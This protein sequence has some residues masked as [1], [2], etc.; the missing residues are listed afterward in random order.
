VTISATSTDTAGN[1]SAATTTDVTKDTVAPSQPTSASL[2][3]GG[4][5]GNAFINAQNLSTGSKGSVSVG[6]VVPAGAANSTSDTVSVTITDGTHTTTPATIASPGSAGGTV[7]PTG[8]NVGSLN[9]GSVTISAVSTDTAGNPSTARTAVVTKDTVAPTFTT[10]PSY[11]D[12]NNTAQD[13]IAGKTSENATVTAVETTPASNTFT[14]PAT[15][16]ATFTVNVAALSGTTGSPI[17][18][19]YSVTATD[20]AGNTSSPA[21]VVSGNDTK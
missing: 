7:T 5:T 1:A 4:G 21:V 15:G 12:K 11:S 9:E 17:A 3:N 8:I 18:F 2:A 6:V 20:P 10:A 13:Q 14:G 16:G 19:S